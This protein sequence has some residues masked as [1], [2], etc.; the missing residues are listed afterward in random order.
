MAIESEAIPA[1]QKDDLE[2]LMLD[3]IDLGI[4]DSVVNLYGR[5][6]MLLGVPLQG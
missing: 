5:L 2:S 3:S 4:E 1:L 6:G